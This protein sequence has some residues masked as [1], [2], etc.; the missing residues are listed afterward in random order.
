MNNAC[1][2]STVAELESCHPLPHLDYVW[3]TQ[4]M[5]LIACIIIKFGNVNRA[6]YK[7]DSVKQQSMRNN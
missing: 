5:K 6:H 7:Q 3:K 4:N 1:L 2:F